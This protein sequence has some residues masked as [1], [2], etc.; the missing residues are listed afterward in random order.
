[1]TLPFAVSYAALCVAQGATVAAPAADRFKALARLRS[2][3]WALVPVAAIVATVAGI[4]AAAGAADA[5]TYL[6]LVTTPP[7]AAVALGYAA[8]GSRPARALAVVPAFAAAWLLRGSLVG[9]AASIFLTASACVTLAALLAAVAPAAWLRVGL[10][11]M[12]A[13]DT[14]LVVNHLLQTPNGILNA[15][16]P[17]AGLPQFQ[18]AEFGSAVMGY[19]DLFE[20]ALLGALLASS[21]VRQRQAALVTTVLALAFGLLFFAVDTL[22]ATVPVAVTLVIFSVAD[23]RSGAGGGLSLRS[24]KRTSERLERT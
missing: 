9:E 23:R 13:A 22:P 18:R 1:V 17:A 5:L 2:V 24:R 8:R 20:A 10:I 4:S 21:P 19:G 6:A 7:L 14:A 3:W 11:L 12:S 16:A 15:A